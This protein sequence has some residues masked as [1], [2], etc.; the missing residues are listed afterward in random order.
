MALRVGPIP[1]QCN[2]SNHEI[3]HNN[4]TYSVPFAFING[5]G[6]TIIIRNVI[7]FII[8]G[9]RVYNNKK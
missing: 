9:R 4:C 3:G 8:T 6:V 2:V 7:N 1:K 5:S